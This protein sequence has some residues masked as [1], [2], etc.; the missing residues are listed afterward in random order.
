MTVHKCSWNDIDFTPI[1]LQPSFPNFNAY[2]QWGYRD[3]WYLRP[4]K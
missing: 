4:L 1:L 2:C 3:E